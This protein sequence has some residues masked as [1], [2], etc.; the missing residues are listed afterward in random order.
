MNRNYD[1]SLFGI[2]SLA[3]RF[4]LSLFSAFSIL[5]F[6]SIQVKSPFAKILGFSILYYYYYYY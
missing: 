4:N 2:R 6:N 1:L 3:L 5:D